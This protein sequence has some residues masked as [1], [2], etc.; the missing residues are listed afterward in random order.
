MKK[1]K[2]FDWFKRTKVETKSIIKFGWKRD[3]PDHR[4]YKFKITAPH[5]LPDI[6]DLRL[7]CPPIYAQ[8]NLGSCFIGETKIPLLDGSV[9]SLKE[10]CENNKNDFFWVYS[11]M[12]NGKIVP[13]KATASKTGI[14]R[15]IIEVILDNG[16]IIKCTPE[17]EFML[18][19]GSYCEA[20]NLINGQSLMPFKRKL[21][22]KQYELIFD[23]S[24]A[25]WH[26]TH[27]M[28]KS[29]F[30]KHKNRD[31]IHHIDFNKH[32]NTPENLEFMSHFEHQ[33]LHEKLFIENVLNKWNG[34]ER[35]RK[36]SSNLLTK[37]HK[38]NPEIFKRASSNG[39]KKTWEIAKTNPDRKK[40]I[41]STLETGRTNPEIRK[42]AKES[43]KKTVSSSEYREKQSKTMSTIMKSLKENNTDGWKNIVASGKNI[44]GKESLRFQIMK[45]GRAMI[46]NNIIINE[47]TWNC[48]RMKHSIMRTK[49]RVRNGKEQIY[50]ENYNKTPKFKTTLKV[51][52]NIDELVDACSNYNAKVLS[53]NMVNK[54]EDVYCLNVPEFSNF[55]LDDGVFV[56]NCTAHALAAA[57]QFE[58]M[59]Q[60]K[61]SWN[62]SRLFIYYNER[63]IENTINED[64]GATMRSGIKTMVKEGVC[65]ENQWEYVEGKFRDKPSH[66][67]YKTALDNQVLEYLRITPHTLYEIK[68]CLADGHLVLFG[69]MIYESMMSDCVAHSGYVP[70]P[71]N[72]DRPIG[73]HAVCCLPNTL[74]TTHRGFISIKDIEIGDMVLT[75]NGRFKKVLNTFSR[76]VNEEIYKISNNCGDD[77]YVTKEHPFY[78]KNYSKLTKLTQTEKT[79]SF[80]TDVEWQNAENL[81][82]GNLLYSPICDEISNNNENII[83]DSDF[84][85][86]LGMY[87][88]DGN[89]NAR[90]SNN[91]NVKSMKLRFSLG[92]DYPELI[93]RCKYLLS[94]Y[95]DNKIGIDNFANH[96]NVV[97]Y[98]TKLSKKIGDICGYA[99]N[100]KI[101]S[102]ILF[103]D[104]KLQKSFIIGW[105]E[106]DG[107]RIN[108]ENIIS[109]SEHVLYQELIFIL[110]RLRLLY[111]ISIKPKHIS[112]I[113]GKPYQCK[114]SYHI[115]ISNVDENW[116]QTRTKHRSIY[117][118]NYLIFKLNNISTE[119]YSGK[120]YNF[121]V[122]DDNSY[123]ANGIAVH[124]CA[125]GYDN[126]KECLIV[127]NS[128]GENW[129]IDGYF[130]LPYWYVTTPNASADYWTIKLVE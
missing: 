11:I 106:T 18:R 98:D 37:L 16:K 17:H 40:E 89:I 87:I 63:L 9:K 120:V 59:K 80:L 84:F 10:L 129:G 110:K 92:K 109:T 127:R 19:D 45:F 26:Y 81:K 119:T 66:N 13:T 58:K 91:E 83:Y 122:E 2:I 8:G 128:W 88:G 111:S 57:F 103:A 72:N 108:N 114:E 65:P 48:E 3:L 39:G 28:V 36:H 121:E 24:D 33:K 78:T 7:K 97:C 4:D 99:K 101:S 85:E 64:A 50:C 112:I 1:W 44:G 94:K 75:H 35:Q 46:D 68:H 61:S 95:S 116:N 49:K 51:F 5:D 107:C 100:K 32:N 90:Y 105:H 62:P 20:Q 73:G 31:I 53:V 104:S 47:D 27:W 21:S 130:Y 126:N 102:T 38:E 41:L 69:L 82:I 52:S 77:L 60:N 86:L 71:D 115:H 113:K 124:N 96:I 118:D 15:E 14:N 123:V 79:N 76:E 23:N 22:D 93:E 42:R 67:C 30:I 56:H 117:Y 25:K 12:K 29:Y 74:I 6:V 54:S 43:Q 125:V 55:A 34:S 70:I